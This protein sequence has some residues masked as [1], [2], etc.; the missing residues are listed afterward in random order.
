MTETRIEQPETFNEAKRQAAPVDAVV[1]PFYRDDHCVIYNADCRDILDSL[2]A[3][4]VLT[5]PPYG[6]DYNPKRSQ[7]SAASGHR[8]ALKKVAADDEPFDPSLLL[9]FGKLILW[10][11]NN[12]AA[13]LPRSHGWF[14]WDKRDAGTLFP[15]FIA[16]DAELAWTN[17]TGRTL[18]FSHRWC[19]HLRDSERDEYWHPTQKPVALMAW[20]LK[21]VEGEVVLDPYMGSG[22]TLVA[23]KRNGRRAI[24]IELDERYCEI[25]ANRLRQGVLF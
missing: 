3:D 11:A 15:G 24:G 9:R 4:I 7:A 5:D 20:C 1:M 6:I 23:A 21:H 13:Q 12:Y 8:K 18:M 17:V 22:T 14:V 25:A 10:G 19:G 2:S 16:S